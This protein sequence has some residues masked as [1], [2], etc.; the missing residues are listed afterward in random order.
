MLRNGII[1]QDYK[2]LKNHVD[3]DET[4]DTIHFSAGY[5]NNI[6]ENKNNDSPFS[7]TQVTPNKPDK[8]PT[9]VTS[10]LENNTTVLALQFIG[11][12]KTST[13]KTQSTLSVHENNQKTFRLELDNISANIIALKSFLM[14]KI[15]DLRQELNQ[16][17]KSLNKQEDL[18]KLKAQLQYLQRENQSLKE[19]NENKIRRIETVL[20]QNNKLLKLNHEIY[21]KNN[22]T[23]YQE[24]SSKECHRHDDFQISSKTAT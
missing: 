8:D 21:N 6:N 17:I 10:D 15:Y 14:N 2:I 3:G 12:Q 4:L 16:P 22:V 24:K 1:D 19:E 7:Y 18:T 13:I 11:T 5:T 9:L 20:K 23:H